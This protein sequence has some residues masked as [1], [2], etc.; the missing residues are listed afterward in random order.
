M[1]LLLHHD[2]DV[3]EWVKERVKYSGNGWKDYTAIGVMDKEV[4]VAGVVYHDYHGHS[5]QMSIATE[6]PKWASRRIIGLL[7]DYPF[8]QLGCVRVTALTSPDN[9]ASRNMLWRLGFKREGRVRKGYGTTDTLIYGL[10][11]EE[12][13]KWSP[14]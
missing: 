3:A 9:H 13:L 7:F 11:R 6:T 4:M 10:L 14:R 12:A 8:R 1:E 5:I 2:Q